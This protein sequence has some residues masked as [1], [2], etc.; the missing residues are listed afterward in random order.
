MHRI[1]S[2]V[3]H[4]I[5]ECVRRGTVAPL[6]RDRHHWTNALD[7]TLLVL[8]GG[9]LADD[10]RLLLVRKQEHTAVE[11]VARFGRSLELLVEEELL[12]VDRSREVVV[13]WHVIVLAKNQVRT[14]AVI[15][16]YVPVRRRSPDL[17]HMH[18]QGLS[19]QEKQSSS[20]HR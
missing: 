8:F 16:A 12:H 18:T 10:T 15:G 5:V 9:R 14:L 13:P 20:G 7:G 3:L 19:D 4:G 11:R 1:V 2:L 17:V 6:R